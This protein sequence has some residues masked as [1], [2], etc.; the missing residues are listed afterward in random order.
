MSINWLAFAGPSNLRSVLALAF[1]T[2]AIAS[3]ATPLR[4]AHPV[5]A[6]PYVRF[7]IESAV[8]LNPPLTAI[9]QA[10]LESKIE[11]PIPD[12]LLTFAIHKPLLEQP[13]AVPIMP[14]VSKAEKACL[15]T[16]IYFEARG[17]SARGQMAVAQVILNRMES[18]RYPDTICGVVYQNSNRRNACQFSF[19]CDGHPDVTREKSAWKRAQTIAADV[20]AGRGDVG[21]VASATHYHADSVQPRWARK[22]KRLSKI[23]RHV[24]YQG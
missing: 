17:E 19:T 1:C 11:I 3:V 6:L 7:V 12:P 8:F 9:E 24:F 23:G 15:A 13:P 20:L 22:L 18:R 5:I 2:T 4:T 14:V 10:D 21:A 16:A